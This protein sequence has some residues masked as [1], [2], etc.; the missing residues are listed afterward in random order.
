MI[1][2]FANGKEP[3]LS[4]RPPRFIRTA[5][6]GPVRNIL[7]RNLTPERPGG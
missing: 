4:P 6:A 3:L 1:E 5:G 7:G 2:Y